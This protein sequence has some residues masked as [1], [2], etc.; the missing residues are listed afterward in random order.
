MN[1]ARSTITETPHPLESIVW[2]A[3]AERD[4]QDATSLAY[5]M[6]GAWVFGKSRAYTTVAKDV[7]GYMEKQGL[8][9]RDSAGWYR[10]TGFAGSAGS[11]G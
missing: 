1:M 9:E 7:L 10:K 5:F 4:C 11:C 2:N 8:I 3:F 6:A